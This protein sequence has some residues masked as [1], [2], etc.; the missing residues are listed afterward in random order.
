ER[1]LA[2]SGLPWTLLRAAQFHQLILLVVQYM[3]KLPVIPLPAGFRF[4]PVDAGEVADQMAQ[5][6]LGRPIGLAPDIA[7]PKVYSMADLLR[8]YLQ[9]THR[10]RLLIPIPLPGQAARAIRAGANLAPERA[11]GHRTWE[12][13]LAE[14]L[15]GVT[16][17]ASG[18]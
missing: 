14:Q 3:A 1:V 11:V 16:D 13:F 18:I 7:G 2:D 5:L 4:Q 8:I 15:A 9:A 10:H 12:E 6:A 17:V